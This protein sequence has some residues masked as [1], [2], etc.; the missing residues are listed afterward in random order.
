[1]IKHIFLGSVAAVAI[2]GTGVLSVQH[3]QQYQHKKQASAVQMIP[4]RQADQSVS[5][6]KQAAAG[7]YQALLVS[8]QQAE[9]GCQTGAKA[10]AILS[11]P[12]K[13]KISPTA[14]TCPAPVQ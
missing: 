6:I 5:D 11:A 1:M 10:Y 4:K 12:L 7:E 14:P 2:A 3:Y 13:A 9:T 8:Y